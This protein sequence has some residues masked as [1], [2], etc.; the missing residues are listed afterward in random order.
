MKVERFDLKKI[1]DSRGSLSFVEN[2]APLPFD[3]DRVIFIRGEEVSHFTAEEIQHPNKL[4][5]IAL[6][7]SCTI[8]V[9]EGELSEDL[10]L[11][12]ADCGVCIHHPYSQC[13]FTLSADAVVLLL[14][15]FEAQREE[16]SSKKIGQSSK[17]DQCRIVELNRNDMGVSL[18]NGCNLPFDIKRAYYLYDVPAEERRGAHAHKEL[19]QL[20]I[21]LNGSFD[22]V[23]DDGS[24][25]QRFSLTEPDKALQIVPGMWRDIENFSSKEAICL[26]LASMLY[27]EADYIRNYEDFL[28]YKTL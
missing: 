1:S 21:P 22:V 7:G 26:V 12:G 18:T 9:S 14:L 3:I 11:E 16:L 28:D 6:S 5:A 4:F 27:S 15:S 8:R 24:Q 10:H 19:Y 20:I 17:V 13:D 2:G 23:L 25:K